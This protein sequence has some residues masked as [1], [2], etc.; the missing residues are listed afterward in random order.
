MPVL[1]LAG[2]QNQ[3]FTGTHLAPQKVTIPIRRIIGEEGPYEM[4]PRVP[5]IAASSRLSQQ[6][7]REGSD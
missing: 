3:I 7:G 1:R 4:M 6:Q 2:G 5:R